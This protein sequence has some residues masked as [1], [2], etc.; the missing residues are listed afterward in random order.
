MSSAPA[1]WH[2]F[3]SPLLCLNFS[4]DLNIIGGRNAL[5]LNEG[6]KMGKRGKEA[7]WRLLGCSPLTDGLSALRE[8]NAYV[9]NGSSP[10]HK[11]T[12]QD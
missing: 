2:D 11:G 4:T 10:K 8:A 7:I 1:F 3:L 9:K 12:N 6:L 5:S